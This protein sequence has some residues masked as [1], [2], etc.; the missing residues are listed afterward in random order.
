L[1]ASERREYLAFHEVEERFAR[2]RFDDRADQNPPVTRIAVSRA[3]FEPQRVACEDV[4][5]VGHGLAVPADER[6]PVVGVDLRRFSA[7]VVADTG[8]MSH[9]LPRRDRPALFGEARQ[10]FLHGGLEVDEPSLMQQAHRGRGHGLRHAANSKEGSWRDR[11][12]LPEVRPTKRL[13]PRE[14]TIDR[15]RDRHAGQVL[16]DDQIPR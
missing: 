16:I 5:C 9:Q 6:K 7:S 8:H 14:F 13:G 15:H 12:A 2:R 4:E 3:G 1:G 10:V 11:H